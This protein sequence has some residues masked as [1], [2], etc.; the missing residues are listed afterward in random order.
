[1]PGTCDKCH[2]TMGHLLPLKSI[3]LETPGLAVPLQLL[4]HQTC[5]TAHVYPMFSG[6]STV[7]GSVCASAPSV[8]SPCPS[9]QAAEPQVS[10]SHFAPTPSTAK[11]CRDPSGLLN[12]T[13]EQHPSAPRATIVMEE[14]LNHTAGQKDTSSLTLSCNSSRE[15][16]KELL[17]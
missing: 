14:E 12:P 10:T 2:R 17:R 1:M 3:P 5:G 16:Y 9:E 8:P 4:Q 15:S 6:H 11:G 13:P 7:G